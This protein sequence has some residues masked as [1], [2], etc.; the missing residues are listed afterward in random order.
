M[1]KFLVNF[2]FCLIIM[3]VTSGKEKKAL[4]FTVESRAGEEEGRGGEGR[5]KS[6]EGKGIG[7][8][9]RGRD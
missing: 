5:R 2:D 1:S 6:V 8:M 4:L 9:W 7:L 3:K